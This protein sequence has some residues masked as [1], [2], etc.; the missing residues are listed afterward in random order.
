MPELNLRNI[1]RDFRLPEL[2]LPEM[3]RDDIAKAL[4]D[5]RKELREV[6]KDLQ[7]FRREFELPKVDPSTAEA[8]RVD[9]AKVVDVVED[10]AKQ[11]ADG[12]KQMADSAKQG[13]LQAVQAAGLAKSPA[14]RRSRKPFLVAGAMTLGVLGLA[15]INSP[16]MKARLRDSAQRAR[17]R[18]AARRSGWDLDDETRAFDAAR[19]AG[20][21]PSTYSG[22][23]DPADSPFTEPPTE[24][25]EGLGAEGDIHQIEEDATAR[26]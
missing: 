19:P 1:R 13:V 8:P 17:E 18:M 15:L 16:G 23:I 14:S 9:V 26:A 24:L 11:V 6:R 4:G 22:A 25:P 7:E 2:R 10:G 12:A 21:E 3:S 20:V 5:A